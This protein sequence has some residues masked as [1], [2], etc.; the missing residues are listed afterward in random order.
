M[1]PGIYF[2]AVVPSTWYLLPSTSLKDDSDLFAVERKLH[3]WGFKRRQL[4][5][6]TRHSG[7]DRARAAT[8]VITC[9]L[10]KPDLQRTSTWYEV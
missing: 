6:D 3:Y 2:T 9:L 4:T 7:E 1:V 8:A 10:L 5:V